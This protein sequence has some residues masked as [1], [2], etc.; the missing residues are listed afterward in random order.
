MKIAVPVDEQSLQSD[1]C[2]SFGRTPF[3]LFYNTETKEESYF[4]NS[5]FNEQS[6]AGIKAAQKIVDEGAQVLLTRHCGENAAEVFEGSVE[7]YRASVGTA[8]ENI[9]AFQ[10]GELQIL[11]EIHPGY[12]KG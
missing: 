5:A 8:Q 12:H 6:G 11:T 9:K 4:D 10:N 7:I 3:F 2:I 1:V